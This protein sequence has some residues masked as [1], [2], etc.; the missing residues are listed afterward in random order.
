MIVRVSHSGNVFS[1]I[2]RIHRR[3]IVAEDSVG[4]GDLVFHCQLKTFTKCKHTLKSFKSSSFI[5]NKVPLGTRSLLCWKRHCGACRITVRCQFSSLRYCLNLQQVER[6]I[7]KYQLKNGW[8]ISISSLLRWTFEFV[9]AKEGAVPQR[10]DLIAALLS[11]AKSALG[12]DPLEL[13]SESGGYRLTNQFKQISWRIADT[14]AAQFASK[15][16]SQI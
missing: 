11:E 5:A 7:C 16:H 15:L 6:Q 8:H 4:I 9:G 14:M 12:S 13:L 2:G 1:Q 10:L 3:V